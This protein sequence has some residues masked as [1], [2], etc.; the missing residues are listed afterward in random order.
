MPFQLDRM[1]SASCAQ[2]RQIELPNWTW[3]IYLKMWTRSCMCMSLHVLCTTL[4][5][6][7][8]LDLQTVYRSSILKIWARNILQWPLSFTHCITSNT[9]VNS[10]IDSIMRL[11]HTAQYRTCNAYT[12][13][14]IHRIRPFYK[15]VFIRMH[16]PDD[17]TQKRV[18]WF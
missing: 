14:I 13:Y 3:M 10:T 4:N 15:I 2:E 1:T 18:C 16:R 17:E 12:S 7:C 5:G 8:E 11:I 9:C 6:I